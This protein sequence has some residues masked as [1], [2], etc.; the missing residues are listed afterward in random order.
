MKIASVV[1]F[2]ASLFFVSAMLTGVFVLTNYSASVADIPLQDLVTGRLDVL[3][4]SHSFWS[5][6]PKAPVHLLALI[7]F[8]A[9]LFTSAII[10]GIVYG[11]R[12][13]L[14]RSLGVTGLVVLAAGILP[15]VLGRCMLRA[16]TFA[17]GE[18]GPWLMFMMLGI[19]YSSAAAMVLSFLSL[20]AQRKVAY[21][22]NESV[23]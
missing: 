4:S 2:V 10:A 1:L 21:C 17:P 16:A 22:K 19:L 23:G 11:I 14:H 9:L 12:F 15:Y 13:K 3:F 5:M 20:L 7:Q 6:Y 18:C 8:D